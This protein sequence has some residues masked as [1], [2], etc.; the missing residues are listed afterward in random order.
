MGSRYTLSAAGGIA[1]NPALTG[2]GRGFWSWLRSAFAV[3]C[4]ATEVEALRLE[5]CLIWTSG[6]CS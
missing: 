5:G 6:L 1:A 4:G 3:D 2:A